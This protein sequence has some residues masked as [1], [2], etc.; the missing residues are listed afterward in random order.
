MANRVAQQRANHGAI[1]V[2]IAH[3]T[4]PRGPHGRSHGA[5]DAG[6]RRLAHV[7]PRTTALTRCH[8]VQQN[9]N[10]SLVVGLGDEAGSRGLP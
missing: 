1:I 10:L 5:S 6:V 4:R 2:T 8:P 9:V 7:T 3:A